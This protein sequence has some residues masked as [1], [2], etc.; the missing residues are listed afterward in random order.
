[1]KGLKELYA[2]AK[3]Y[4]IEKVRFPYYLKT[5]HQQGIGGITYDIECFSEAD[6]DYYRQLCE[7]MSTYLFF[8][9]AYDERNN[10]F[11]QVIDGGYFGTDNPN[12]NSSIDVRGIREHIDGKDYALELDIR[13]HYECGVFK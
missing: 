7:T 13:N 6:V 9:G 12:H 1:M 11:H 2:Y 3:V 4:C 5:L 10:K 8:M